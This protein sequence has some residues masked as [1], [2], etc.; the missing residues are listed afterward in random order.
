MFADF[1]LAG[2][3][4]FAS[5]FKSYKLKIIT[6]YI[7]HLQTT[8]RFIEQLRLSVVTSGTKENRLSVITWVRLTLSDYLFLSAV[9]DP[10]GTLPIAQTD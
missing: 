1:G 7:F 10:F 3:N 9:P 4:I 2:L 8:S 5:N 6:E